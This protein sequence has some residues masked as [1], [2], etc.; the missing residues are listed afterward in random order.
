MECFHLIRESS[1]KTLLSININNLCKVYYGKYG[2]IEI[3]LS[4]NIIVLQNY[5]FKDNICIEIYNIYMIHT[6]KK[7]IIDF[8][9]MCLI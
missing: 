6:I 5:H 8:H 2:N 9:A 3:F 7:V 4:K 1:I